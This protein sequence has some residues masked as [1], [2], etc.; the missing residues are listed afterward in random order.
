[1]TGPL[2][3]QMRTFWSA[4][5]SAAR[6]A[7]LAAWPPAPASGTA[8]SPDEAMRSTRTT[9]ANRN[10]LFNPVPCRGKERAGRSLD[11]RVEKGQYRGQQP[12]LTAWDKPDRNNWNG[13]DYRPCC[14]DPSGA[15]MSS[16]VHRAHFSFQ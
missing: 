15:L 6:P 16:C 1:M 5:V 8:V 12:A 2:T 9:G 14:E 3:G 7:R 13:R 11:G 4:W 10:I